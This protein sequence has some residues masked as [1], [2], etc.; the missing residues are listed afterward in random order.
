MSHAGK[1]CCI[2]TFY[3]KILGLDIYSNS[4]LALGPIKG[5]REREGERER[6][7]ERG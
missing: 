7:R 6:E 2:S 3:L 1:E 5:Q 4:E